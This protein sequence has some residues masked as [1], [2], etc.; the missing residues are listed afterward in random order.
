MKSENTSGKDV[1]KVEQMAQEL[2]D[3]GDPST[4][5]AYFWRAAKL[6][7]EQEEWTLAAANY[8][9]AAYCY[10]IDGALDKA[11]KDC[12]SAAE[13]YRRAGLPEKA[14]AVEDW[15]ANL[16]KQPHG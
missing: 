2:L 9:K 13:A 3:R 6:H 10:E 11:A 15:A 16:I 7:G 1:T 12:Y 5:M 8:E 14:K 4:A